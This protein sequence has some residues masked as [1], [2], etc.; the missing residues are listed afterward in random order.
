MK[1]VFRLIC[2]AVATTF[3]FTATAKAGLY[4]YGLGPRAVAMGQA[5]TAAANDPS[6]ATYNPAALIQ[7]RDHQGLGMN[8]PFIQLVSSGSSHELILNGV[9]QGAE[10][11]PYVEVAFMMPVF[12]RVV[13]GGGLYASNNV[14][15]V[16]PIFYGPGISRWG[17]E[18]SYG[19][20]TAFA[21]QITK[22]FSV[23]YAGTSRLAYNGST[24]NLDIGPI[25]YDVLGV[26]LVESESNINPAFELDITSEYGYKVGAHY[27]P[28]D[29]VSLGVLYRYRNTASLNIP[30]HVYTGDLMGEFDV[31]ISQIHG[32]GIVPTSITGGMAIYPIDGLTLAFDLSYQVYS[33]ENDTVGMAL[34]SDNPDFNTDYPNVDLEDV[35][36]P[37]FGGEWKDKFK[38]RFERVEYAIRAGYQFFPSPYAQ[39]N[40]ED[41]MSGVVDNDAHFFSGGFMLGYH[42]YRGSLGKGPSFVGVEYFYEYIH[43]VKRKHKSI[44]SNPPVIVSEGNVIFSGIGLTMKF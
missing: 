36:V 14:V 32:S 2:I 1:Y 34:L 10:Y 29:W 35:L 33:K 20:T 40:T 15:A 11:S 31:V 38:G 27:R 19:L 6:A 9:D 26:E 28:F 3:M 30:L 4:E 21:I 8:D 41:N 42:P 18:H 17:P 43:L 25:L 13:V 7:A 39:V 16:I 44:E 12:K 37:R 23:G 24:L 5:M 22:N